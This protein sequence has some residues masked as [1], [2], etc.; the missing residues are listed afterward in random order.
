M[1]H[2]PTGPNLTD[3]RRIDM[4]A[5]ILQFPIRPANDNGPNLPPPAAEMARAHAAIAR[6]ELRYAAQRAAN[7]FGRA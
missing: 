4:A 5:L 6:D 3:L 2:H 7:S 1:Y